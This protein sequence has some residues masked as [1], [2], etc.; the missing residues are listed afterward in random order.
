[1]TRKTHKEGLTAPRIAEALGCS[2]STV[3][4]LYQKA[5]HLWERKETALRP[6]AKTPQPRLPESNLDALRAVRA[7]RQP[8]VSRPAPGKKGRPHKIPRL[9]VS[10]T[11]PD[12]S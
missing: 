9:P 5:P 8:R 2:V 6:R 1:M 4:R 3:W 11:P 10:P 7:M 12:N